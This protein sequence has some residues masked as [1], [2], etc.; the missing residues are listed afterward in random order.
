MLPEHLMMDEFKSVKDVSGKMSFIYADAVTHRIVDIL[1]D[2]RLRELKKHFYKYPL[3]ER[4]RVKS[5]SID[6]YELYM[7]LVKEL[8]PNA[9]IIIDRFHIIQSLNRALNMTRVSVMNM[10]RNMNRPLYNKFK[11]FW[12]LV[13]KP[14]EQLNAFEYKST[15]LFKEWKTTKGIV[16]YLL[17]IDNDLFNTHHCTNALRH[18][19]KH[20]D[21]ESFI[22]ILYS[23]EMKEVAPKMQPVLRTLKR[24]ESMILNTIESP[25]ITNGPLEG[26]NNKIKLIKRVSFGYRNF[27]NL[28]N[29]IILCTRLFASNPKKEIKQLFAA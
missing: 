2:G 13:L 3:K 9:N 19:L 21:S 14:Y 12:R 18:A 11:T 28:R 26:I 29:R 22:E 8:F 17:N 16:D 20:N 15:R 4:K 6:M 23:I 25:S 1:P 10:F 27:D 24:H 5:V 7:S